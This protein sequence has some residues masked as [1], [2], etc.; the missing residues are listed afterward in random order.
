MI[1]PTACGAL[2]SARTTPQPWQNLVESWWSPGGTLA[3]PRG[4]LP[5]GRP[6]PPRSLSGL[7]PQSFQLLGKKSFSSSDR[8]LLKPTGENK[9]IFLNKWKMSI[10]L[11][12]CG[13]TLSTCHKRVN[14]ELRLAITLL[15]SPAVS[16]WRWAIQRARARV[17]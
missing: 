17:G 2:F 16:G 3:D 4:T 11:Q 15:A 5:Q 9:Q 1:S 14:G 6:G 7:R 10:E 13:L 12:K 8:F